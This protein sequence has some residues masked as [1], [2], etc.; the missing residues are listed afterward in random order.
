MFFRVEC[1]GG[2]T[3]ARKLHQKTLVE[4]I[5]H[6]TCIFSFHYGQE[7]PQCEN[8]FNNRW[9]NSDPWHSWEPL[10]YPSGPSNSVIPFLPLRS[11]KRARREN[12][13]KTRRFFRGKC[14]GGTQNMLICI[15]N[16]SLNR[17]FT[18]KYIFSSTPVSKK[19]NVKN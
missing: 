3:H 1:G 4:P 9:V 18:K 11:V 5:F 7:N 2:A 15:K 14:G 13:I 10:R 12:W 16:L 19:R 8:L 6:E 17:F